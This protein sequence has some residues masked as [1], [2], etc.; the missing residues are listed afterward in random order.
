MFFIAY[1]L[2]IIL[3]LDLG[4]SKDIYFD[5]GMATSILFVF[6]FIIEVIA[7]I[8]TIYKLTK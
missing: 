1:F 5:L 2:I 7:V 6:S 3:T 8:L 4:L